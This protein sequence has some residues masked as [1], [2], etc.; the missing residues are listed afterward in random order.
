[1]RC[2]IAAKFRTE[3]SFAGRGE[4]KNMGLLTRTNPKSNELEILVN[5]EWLPF[6]AYREKQIDDAYDK[7]IIFLRD[8]LNDDTAQELLTKKGTENG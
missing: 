4:I 1:M 6:T 7:S 2:R 8:R 5:D 3:T